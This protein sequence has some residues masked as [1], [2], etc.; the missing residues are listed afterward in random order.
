MKQF[1]K[2]STVF[3]AISLCIA[4]V[5]FAQSGSRSYSNTGASAYSEIIGQLEPIDTFQQ[6]SPAQPINS[7]VA[8]PTTTFA[9]PP[10]AEFQ[11]A[12]FFQATNQQRSPT[13]WRTTEAGQLWTDAPPNQG[14]AGWVDGNMRVQIGIDYL[15]FSRGTAADNLLAFDDAGNTSS[16]AD[17]DP[18][19]DTT[20]RY[21]VLFAT[22]GGTGF[23][24]LAYDF[25]EFS[26]SLTLEGEGI[27]PVFF[28]S[29]PID[30]VESY[31]ASY[32]SRLKNYE[33]NVWGRK[34]ERVK[35]GYGLRY[36][37]LDENFDIDFVEDS[38]S[39][40]TTTASPDGFFSRTDN[41]IFGAQ[42]MAQLYRPVTSGLYLTGGASGGYGYNRIDVDSDTANID[43]HSDDD[44]GTGFFSFNG[45]VTMRVAKG[46]RVNAGYEGLLLTSVALAPDQSAAAEFAQGVPEIQT[47][48]LYFGGAYIGAVLAF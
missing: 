40:G 36:V 30:P 2:T 15:Y 24:I 8:Q 37:N 18:G 38:G 29:I 17:I 47:G 31:E 41:N 7:P 9:Q 44:T 11:N 5:S 42:L 33:F 28:D 23:E 14:N 25:Q 22:E 45:G 32:R 48:T 19:D 26:G 3:L 16:I 43:T 34:S 20:V 4:S 12:E 39:T 46:L 35:L 1:L 27:T 13:G 10:N 21:R 6:F